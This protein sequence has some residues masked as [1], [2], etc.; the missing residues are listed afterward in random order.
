MEVAASLAA[1][2]VEERRPFALVTGDSFV[3]PGEGPGQLERVLDALARVD[4]SIADPA[5]N[6]PVDPLACVLVSVDGEGGWGDSLVVGREAR[7]DP[8]EAA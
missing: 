3:A 5:P 1:R 6:P 2:A 7:L 8:E 4:F